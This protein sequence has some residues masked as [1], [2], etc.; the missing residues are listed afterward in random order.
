MPDITS[1]P[2]HIP[3]RS[4]LAEADYRAF[5]EEAYHRMAAMPGYFAPDEGMECVELAHIIPTVPETVI[6][7]YVGINDA[8]CNK[9]LAT[10]FLVRHGHNNVFAFDPHSWSGRDDVPSGTVDAR[11]VLN[12]FGPPNETWDPNWTYVMIEDSWQT[13]GSLWRERG[14]IDMIAA[15]FEDF[16]LLSDERESSVCF[17]I[18]ELAFEHPVNKGRDYLKE[19]RRRGEEKA[20]QYGIPAGL[21]G[22]TDG[23]APV[24]LRRGEK[25][26]VATPDFR[27]CA[28]AWS[29]L[30]PDNRTLAVVNEN[31]AVP[32]DLIIEKPPVNPKFARGLVPARGSAD[33]TTDAFFRGKQV[34][35]KPLLAGKV[36][37]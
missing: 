24:I 14:Y 31:S 3:E 33:M 9:G 8:V 26:Y 27:P 13:P 29:N 5:L 34:Q 25:L 35:R 7:I 10:R 23:L 17:F 19:A 1:R 6:A 37:G 22:E 21:V 30:H 32:L 11:A 20:H 15:K 2:I 16:T 36:R 4:T 18:D 12:G 28:H